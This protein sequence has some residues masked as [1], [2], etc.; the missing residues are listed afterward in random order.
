MKRY[1][2]YLLTLL[3]IANG[4]GPV[5]AAVEQT[6]ISAKELQPNIADTATSVSDPVQLA[7]EECNDSDG[8][9]ECDTHADQE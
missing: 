6:A 9:G 5:Q 1:A 7:Q 3:T 4:N 2:L 8:D